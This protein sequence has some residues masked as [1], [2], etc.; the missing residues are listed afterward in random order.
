MS[1]KK[2]KKKKSSKNVNEIVAQGDSVPIVGFGFLEPSLIAL[3]AQAGV[4]EI[5]YYKDNTDETID[6][7]RSCDK[8]PVVVTFSAKK[9]QKLAIALKEYHD[10]GL[11][12]IICAIDSAINLDGYS[13]DVFD[14]KKVMDNA[15]TY[16][17]LHRSMINEKLGSMVGLKVDDMKPGFVRKSEAAMLIKEGTK[18]IDDEEEAAAFLR[19]SRKK[20]KSGSGAKE[21]PVADFLLDVAPKKVAKR[22]KGDDKKSSKK[23]KKKE[24]KSSDKYNP[25]EWD[26]LTSNL[27]TQDKADVLILLSKYIVGAISKNEFVAFM[28]EYTSAD[29]IEQWTDEVDSSKKCRKIKKAIRKVHLADASLVDVTSGMKPT[30]KKKTRLIQKVLKPVKKLRF[31]K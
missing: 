23:S 6:F 9:A 30:L 4:F 16:T 3:S 13:I 27:E 17:K 21:R 7:V 14:G 15:Y 22:L 28:S 1:K 19:K 24:K 25:L 8:V 10:N 29:A 12:F 2:R 20:K 11:A 18:V 5:Y 31:L 26:H